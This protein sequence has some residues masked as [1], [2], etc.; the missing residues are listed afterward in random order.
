M[1]N[2]NKAKI[3]IAEIIK[4]AAVLTAICIVVTFLLAVTNS[5]TAGKIAENS[6]EKAAESRLTVLE[7]YSYVQ[8]DDE[9]FVFEAIQENG[10][11]LGV[12][13][14]TEA[15]GYGGTI[16][17]MTGIKLD[18]EISG[19]N[20]LSMNETPGMGAKAKES[21]FLN[22][23]ISQSE[24]NMSV[25]KDGGEIDAISGAT[26]T[27]RAVTQAVNDAIDLAAPY[28]ANINNST[29]GGEE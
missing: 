4:P 11:A 22:Q 29:T 7:A 23:Y 1:E 15:S 12:V 21:S 5:F 26:I 24:S 18:G 28:L 17:V 14:V 13:V 9:G 27:S 6:E 19:V 2:K 10:E 25:N 20:I 16:E 8:L 3:N